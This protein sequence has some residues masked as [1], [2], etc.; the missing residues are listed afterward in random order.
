MGVRSP[1][2]DLLVQVQQSRHKL[3]IVG[4]RRGLS[5]G[6]GRSLYLKGWPWAADGT[7]G[8]WLGGGVKRAWVACLQGMYRSDH[9]YSWAAGTLGF[10]DGVRSWACLKDMAPYVDCLVSEY[11]ACRCATGSALWT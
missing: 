5:T 1:H 10:A 6:E 7:L 3:P 2:L 9:P 4:G 11:P 8:W